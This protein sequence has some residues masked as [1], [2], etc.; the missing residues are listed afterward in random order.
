MNKSHTKNES[1]CT[2]SKITWK[3]ILG[4]MSLPILINILFLLVIFTHFN[5]F[6]GAPITEIFANMLL[7]VGNWPSLLLGKYPYVIAGGGEVVYEGLG[8]TNPNAFIIDLVG[9][10]Y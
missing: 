7:Y 2:I 1:S 6:K 4:F 3:V 8:W 5:T 10:D 9:W